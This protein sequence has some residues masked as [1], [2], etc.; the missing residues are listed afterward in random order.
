[1]K[2]INSPI[3]Y[4]SHG[5]LSTEAVA[6]FESLKKSIEESVVTAIDENLPFEM[7][8]NDS[9]VALA[10]TLNQAGWPVAFFSRTSQGPEVRHP[11]VEK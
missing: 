8:T 11:S 10:V 4:G 1:M 5:H 6:A 9:E 7:E 3:V 2:P